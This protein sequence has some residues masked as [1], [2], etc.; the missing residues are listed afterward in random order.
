MPHGCGGGLADDRD[1]ADEIADQDWLASAMAV[2]NGSPVVDASLLRKD[3]QTIL[4]SRLARSGASILVSAEPV[5]VEELVRIW[6]ALKLPYQLSATYS[7]RV[8]TA[9]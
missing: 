3:G 9:G 8:V 2:L 1:A 4:D 6:T 5:A 7:V